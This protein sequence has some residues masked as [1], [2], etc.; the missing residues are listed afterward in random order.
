MNDPRME[1]LQAALQ[2]EQYAKDLMALETVEDIKA[3]LAEAGIDFTTEEV[4]DLVNSV[5]ASMNSADGELSE[6][7]LDNVAGG[8]I[9]LGPVIFLGLTAAGVYIGWKAAG[10]CNR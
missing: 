10:G 7:A 8:V 9:P 3:K 6:D 4:T 5:V 2:D 1:K